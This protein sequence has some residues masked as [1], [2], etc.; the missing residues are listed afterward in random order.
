M[1]WLYLLALGF[2]VGVSGAMLPG[3]L[4][5]Y[6]IAES[7]KKGWKTGFYVIVGHAIVEVALMV[8]LAAGVAALMSS[9]LFVRAVSLLGG[10]FMLYTSWALHRSKWAV[11]GGR[12]EVKY[13]TVV[14]GMMFTALNPG[15]PIWWATAGARLL[16]E[17]MKNAGLT[18][19]G[20][21]FVGHWGADFG[22]FILV[23][24]LVAKGRERLLE[25][26][27]GSVKSLL[28]LLLLAIGAYFLWSAL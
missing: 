5:V 28:A 23:S 14:G 12:D 16:L 3:P 1:D 7:L 4:L 27:V 9:E 22:Y 24:C 6:T 10:V 2:V 25:R 17:G 15:F 26:Y 8:V 19:A 11:G 13:G 21:V 18:G 20:L